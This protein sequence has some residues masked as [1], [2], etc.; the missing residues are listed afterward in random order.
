MELAGRKCDPSEPTRSL[1]GAPSELGRCF[2]RHQKNIKKKLR[3][4]NGFWVDFGSQNCS[5]FVPVCTY[6]LNVFL[7]GYLIPILACFWLIQ[8]TPRAQ[9]CW[10]GQYFHGFGTSH[11]CIQVSLKSAPKCFQNYIKMRPKMHQKINCFFNRF[12]DPFCFPKIIQNGSQNG[13]EKLWKFNGWLPNR[14]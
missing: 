3:F 8:H 7:N 6:F 11:A 1:L 2:W 14:C 12:F 4:L 5:F 9:I 10:Q 13:T